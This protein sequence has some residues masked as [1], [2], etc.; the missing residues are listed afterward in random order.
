MKKIVLVSLL[1]FGYT[2]SPAQVQVGVAAGGVISKTNMPPFQAANPGVGSQSMSSKSRPGFYAGLVLEK[3]WGPLAF[4]PQVNVVQKG[5]VLH[6]ESIGGT[7]PGVDNVT[8]TDRYSFHYLEVPLQLVYN[9]YAP[10]GKIFLGGG[11]FFA[12][13][14]GARHRQSGALREKLDFELDDMNRTDLGLQ[15]TAGYEVKEGWFLNLNYQ[16]SFL[17]VYKEV[18]TKNRAITFG[19]GKFL[20][21]RY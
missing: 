13:A 10:R 6:F 9:W 18:T 14:L 7:S 20:S 1:A 3:A 2:S 12:Y 17:N 5:D 8:Y 15:V 16:H 21:Y 11:P 4:R 19:V